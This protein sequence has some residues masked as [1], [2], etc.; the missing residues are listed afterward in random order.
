M[1]HGV[2]GMKWG[3]RR[4][5]YDRSRAPEGYSIRQQVKEGKA[6]AA[7][8]TSSN[9]KEA[10]QRYK[11]IRKESKQKIKEYR[12]YEKQS[13]KYVGNPKKVTRQGNQYINKNGDRVFKE[14][15]YAVTMSNACKKGRRANRRLLAATGAIAVGALLF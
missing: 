3:V 10:R 13:R 9:K 1:H 12:G 6:K 2:K 5:K 4:D 11:E 15:V 14:E 7:I 8:K